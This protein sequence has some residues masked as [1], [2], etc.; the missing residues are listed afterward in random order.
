MDEIHKG[1]ENLIYLRYFKLSKVKE[2]PETC[3]ELLNMQIFHYLS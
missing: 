2:L 3:C 1:L